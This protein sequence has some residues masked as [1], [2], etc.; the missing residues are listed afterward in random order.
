[1][2]CAIES[3]ELSHVEQWFSLGH[4][5]LSLLRN[6]PGCAGCRNGLGNSVVVI[7]VR[8]PI[9]RL[10]LQMRI[11]LPAC[12]CMLVW[13]IVQAGWYSFFCE[14]HIHP[15]P[16]WNLLPGCR[17]THLVLVV[18]NLSRLSLDFPG[19]YQSWNSTLN[20]QMAMKWCTN[21][22]VA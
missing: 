15:L 9:I 16:P 6:A 10:T 4:W 11:A 2:H 5:I 20:S 13:C 19:C 21:L 1:M 3:S 17:Q 8:V 12:I 14:A 22:E 7:R 18:P